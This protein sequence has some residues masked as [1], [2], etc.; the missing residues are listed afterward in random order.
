MGVRVGVFGVANFLDHEK[1]IY[2]KYSVANC[3]LDPSATFF[4][5]SIDG[6]LFLGPSR[7]MTNFILGQ[8]I[9]NIYL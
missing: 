8:S 6:K 1:Y 5:G 7:G 3:F 2:I 4:F 9:H